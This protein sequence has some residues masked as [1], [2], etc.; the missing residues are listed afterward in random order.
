VRRSAAGLPSGLTSF[1]AGEGVLSAF[2]TLSPKAITAL[3]IASSA[4]DFL[5]SYGESEE[6]SDAGLGGSIS[7]GKGN[8]GDGC[9]E[10]SERRDRRWFWNAVELSSGRTGESVDRPMTAA[11]MSVGDEGSSTGLVSG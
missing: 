7:A 4:C 11:I 5:P 10:I 9:C 1:E 6:A 3:S 8:D 2:H